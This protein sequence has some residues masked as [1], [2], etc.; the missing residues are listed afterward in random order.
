M[1]GIATM[2]ALA[3]VYAGLVAICAGYDRHRRQLWPGSPKPSAHRRSTLALAGWALLALALWVD[4]R[5]WS[6]GV[7]WTMW[8]GQLSVATAL[9]VIQ[10]AYRPKPV[11]VLA[12]GAASVAVVALVVG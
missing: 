9:L 11:P 1:S 12:I 7:G 6:G 10:L 3:L 8:F 4:L 2:A 5:E